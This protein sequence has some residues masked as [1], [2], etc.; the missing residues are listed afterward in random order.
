ML[1][2]GGLAILRLAGGTVGWGIQFQNPVFLAVMIAMLG[3]F[4]VSL[5]DRLVIP[6]PRFAQALA[7]MAGDSAGTVISGDFLAGMLATIL[8]TPC[9]APFVGT[10]VAVALS[11]GMADLFG[12]FW[13]LGLAL[14]RPGFLWRRGRHSWPSCRAP[15][16]GWTG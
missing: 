10:A 14:R 8:A 2:A 13:R 9:S 1:L 5:L 12:I 16:P 7:G 3:L 4:A 15:V 11:G 6:V